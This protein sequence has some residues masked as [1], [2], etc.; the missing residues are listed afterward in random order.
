[1]KTI[2]IYISICLLLSGCGGLGRLHSD[3]ERGIDT[4]GL[5]LMLDETIRTPTLKNSEIGVL[6]FVDLNNLEK[7]EPLGRF[8][9]EKLM[10]H[11]FDLGYRVVEMRLGKTF[12]YAENKGELLLSRLKEE[13]RNSSHK[14]LKSVLVGTYTRAGSRIYIS[15]RLVELET[16]QVRAS[17]EI[18]VHDGRYLKYL[19]ADA[20]E[21]EKKAA[22]ADKDA[23]L[24]DGTFERFPVTP[25]KEKK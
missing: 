4:A 24:M 9:Q 11:L 7:A 19:L 12:R 20:S 16:E 23:A 21:P 10:F 3:P 13:L 22:P 2:P 15:C 25:A 17:G 6:T 18:F 8:L 1:M 14:E 5:A